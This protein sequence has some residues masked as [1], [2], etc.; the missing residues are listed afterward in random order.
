[1]NWKCIYHIVQRIAGRM[2]RGLSNGQNQRWAKACD[3][4]VLGQWTYLTAWIACHVITSRDMG[5]KSLAF[6]SFYVGNWLWLS[7]WLMI[8]EF[9]QR[10]TGLH[11]LGSQK[12]WKSLLRFHLDISPG[13][14]ILNFFSP[15][16]FCHSCFDSPQHL[17]NTTTAYH[18][19]RQLK[20]MEEVNTIDQRVFYLFLVN[21]VSTMVH[22]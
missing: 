1:M 22:P 8:W 19:P 15:L 14:S 11:K 18:H 4:K 2:R 12:I 7:L 13:L 16:T 3:F 5:S 20:A 17:V 10:W 6:P 9:P 21:P